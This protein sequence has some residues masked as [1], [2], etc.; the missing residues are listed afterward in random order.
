[1]QQPED[2]YLQSEPHLGLKPSEGGSQDIMQAILTAQAIAAIA[3]HH[4]WTGLRARTLIQQRAWSAIIPQTATLMEFLP[5][6][7][8]Q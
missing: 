2:F 8:I 4:A 3:C 6:D 7:Q 1:M 5:S